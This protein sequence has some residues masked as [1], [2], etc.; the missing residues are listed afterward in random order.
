MRLTV[1]AATLA[2]LLWGAPAFAGSAPDFDGDGVSDG[3]DNCSVAVN[4][5]QDDTDADDCG[6]LCDADYE[7]D[8]TVDFGDFGAVIANFGTG[9]EELCHVEPI[10]GCTVGFGSFGFV[11]A[12]FGSAPGPSGTTAGTVACP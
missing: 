12:N 7:Q 9:N 10:P 1:F 11:V 4:A 3:L 2:F 5:A 8:G 6:N